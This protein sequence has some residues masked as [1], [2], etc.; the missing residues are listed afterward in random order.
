MTDNTRARR[1]FLAGGVGFATLLA[2]L[3]SSG[4]AAA[5]NAAR[6]RGVG[7]DLSTGAG[8]A[9]IMARIAGN[10]NPAATKHGWYR[11]RIMG[12]APGEAVRD[13]F[14]IMGMSS[15]RLEPLKD[16]PGWSLLQK[17]VGF[18]FDLA[19]GAI[20]DDWTNTYTGE[21]VEVMHIANASVS[22]SIEPVVRDSGFYDDPVKAKESERPFILPWQ[23]AGDRLFVEQHINLW[24][25]NPLDPA[26][27]K[28]ESSGPMIQVSDMMSFNV[29]LSDVQNPELTSLENWGS[30]VHV[31]PWQPWMLM[32]TAP[33]HCLYNCFT[34]SADRLDDVPADIVAAV[35][36]RFPEFQ[37]PPTERGKSEPSLIRFMREREPAPVKAS[38]GGAS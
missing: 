25:N 3:P 35:R 36:A 22:R 27:W 31:K 2:S 13:L 4:L 32:G 20:V 28:R 34:G 15:Q 6:L 7:V 38:K 16:R 18:F 12:V 29:R 5:A 26:V 30:W 8:N 23:R 1:E 11:G 9:D 37:T 17:E 33:G 10:T 24:A 19:T 14:G 21:R